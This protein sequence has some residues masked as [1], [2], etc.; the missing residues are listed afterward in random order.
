MFVT[1]WPSPR[2]PKPKPKPVPTPGPIAPKDF[3]AMAPAER[4]DLLPARAAARY[5][6]AGHLAPDPE[7]A[8]VAPAPPPAPPSPEARAEEAEGW[9]RACA[10]VFPP[11]PAGPT[12][13][14]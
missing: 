6:T 7:P 4:P 9:A 11:A 2:A 1:T 10:A 8:A 5:G 14:D 3:V 13:A 12:A